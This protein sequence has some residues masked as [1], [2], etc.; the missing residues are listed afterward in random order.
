MFNRMSILSIA[1]LVTIAL[2]NDVL[3]PDVQ[4]NLVVRLLI[5]SLTL[6]MAIVTLVSFVIGQTYAGKQKLLLIMPFQKTSLEA[7]LVLLSND[8]GQ[9]CRYMLSHGGKQ[10]KKAKDTRVRYFGKKIY[11]PRTNT[12]NLEG[13]KHVPDAI[14]VREQTSWFT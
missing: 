11:N 3:P 7:A 6:F 8:D 2:S 12:F 5:G 4:A 14:T 1:I 13:W 9:V 10:D